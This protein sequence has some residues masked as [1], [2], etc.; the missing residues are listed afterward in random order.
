MIKIK[1][2][3][4]KLLVINKK[5]EMSAL[6]S[7]IAFNIVLALIPTLTVIILIASYFSISLETVMDLVRKIIPGEVSEILIDALS[8]KGFDSNIGFFT[9][10]AFVVAT[11]GTYA[12]IN[13]SNMLY[14]VEET[15]LLKDRIKAAFLLI[16]VII[17]LMFILIVPVFGN[18]I[19]ELLNWFGISSF[20]E[21]ILMVFDIIKWPVSYLIMYMILKVIY[22]VAPSKIIDSKDTTVGAVFTS[23]AWVILSAVFSIYLNKFAHYDIIYGNLSSI[24]ILMIW[25][26]LISYIFVMGLA[27]NKTIIDKKK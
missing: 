26:Y 21:S 13:A 14:D 3:L 18:K 6:P 2:Y 23:V 27:I 20:D 15:D 22:T 25:I 16:M 24:I 17:L 9:I 1:E 7:N 12:I 10:T 5:P 11:N 19:L 8:G 4:Q